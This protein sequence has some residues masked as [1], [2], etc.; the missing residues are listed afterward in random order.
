MHSTLDIT[1]PQF[2][3]ATTAWT[4]AFQKEHLGPDG[5]PLAVV[6]FVGPRTK[7]AIQTA[8]I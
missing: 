5:T 6:G 3:P 4:K 2:G 8:M 1:S 7:W